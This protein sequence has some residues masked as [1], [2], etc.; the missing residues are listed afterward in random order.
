MAQP[1]K[2]KNSKDK[3]MKHIDQAGVPVASATDY[4]GIRPAKLKDRREA[5]KKK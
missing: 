4:T 5:F 1:S 2:G 3:S